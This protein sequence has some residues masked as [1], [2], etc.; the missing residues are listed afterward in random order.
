MKCAV[1]DSTNGCVFDCS[2]SS[3]WDS[4]RAKKFSLVRSKAM[5]LVDFYPH[6]RFFS[7]SVGS[8]RSSDR[9]S[10]N[11]VI[12]YVFS[13]QQRFQR[14]AGFRF[15]CTSYHVG[16]HHFRKGVGGCVVQP[17][18]L[19]ARDRLFKSWLRQPGSKLVSCFSC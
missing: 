10:K 13:N 11:A 17:N 8:R 4:K 3:W 14:K 18:F 2:Q 9:Q 6:C 5:L 7:W 16:N 12:S 1:H 19:L 15:T